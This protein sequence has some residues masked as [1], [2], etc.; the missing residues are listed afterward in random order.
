MG[1]SDVVIDVIGVERQLRPS[2]SMT[3]T[4]LELLRNAPVLLFQLTDEVSN[5]PARCQLVRRYFT[6]RQI[7]LAVPGVDEMHGHGAFGVYFAPAF[8]GQKG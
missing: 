5:G 7:D 2:A 3:P 8:A 4:L 1:A 6:H